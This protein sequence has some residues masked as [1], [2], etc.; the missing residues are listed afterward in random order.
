MRSSLLTADGLKKVGIK[1]G[2]TGQR[3]KSGGIGQISRENVLLTA[4][5]QC[6]FRK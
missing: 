3:I 2:G 6:V 5:L 4:H 1:S